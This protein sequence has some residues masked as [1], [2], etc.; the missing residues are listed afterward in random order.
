MSY[1][2]PHPQQ[3]QPPPQYYQG[4]GYPAQQSQPPV[5][6]ELTAEQ[7]ALYSEQY[8]QQQLYLQQQQHLYA[9][10]MQAYHAAQQQ[11]H[12]Q[13]TAVAATAGADVNVD[14]DAPQDLDENE[15]V[16]EIDGQKFIVP[17]SPLSEEEEREIKAKA[18]AIK[19]ED[20]HLAHFI[21]TAISLMLELAVTYGDD[22]RVVQQLRIMLK[23][24]DSKKLQGIMCGG[25]HTR[26]KDYY[27]A[28]EKRDT[29]AFITN[30]SGID[31][32]DNIEF[33]SKYA[34]LME[35]YPD[36]AKR[37]RALAP[38][39]A[40]IDNLNMRARLF[41][42]SR[43]SPF[44]AS[45]IN[46]GDLLSKVTRSLSDANIDDADDGQ[47]PKMA[48]PTVINVGFEA[49]YKG[50]EAG[51]SMGDI[52]K[53]LANPDS[54]DIITNAAK[55]INGL[56]GGGSKIANIAESVKLAANIYSTQEKKKKASGARYN[57]IINGS[58][59]TSREEDDKDERQRVMAFM[60]DL[61]EGK[62]AGLGDLDDPAMQAMLGGKENAAGMMGMLNMAASMLN[63]NGAQHQEQEGE[64]EEEEKGESSNAS[65]Q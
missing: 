19:A 3:Q 15:E 21:A 14:E 5:Q 45:F 41:V 33:G 44:V 64:E 51:N 32:L 8:A 31:F 27:N 30:E 26:M 46:D 39:W 13:Q 4:Y 12:Q 23:Y 20:T 2:H 49:V 52:L 34:E 62:V 56:E 53:Q 28:L 59:A 29:S 35:Q 24:V 9:Q 54:L 22:D 58:T 42:I 50:M 65:G 43:D 61:T 60:K 37:E 47:T 36:E 6:Q 48:L 55:D 7:W 57:A 63:Q 16:V 18:L 11:Q 17:K 1:P 40:A 38:I 25:Y 10:Q